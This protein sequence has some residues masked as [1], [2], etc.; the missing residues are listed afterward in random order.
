MSATA[1]MSPRT[2]ARLIGALLLATMVGGG[3]AQ[4]LVA[5]SIIVSGD[6]ATTAH[7]ILAHEAL[8]RLGFAVYLVELACQIAMTVLSYQLLK[9]ASKTAAALALAFG[10]IGCTIKTLARLFFFAPLLV[11]GGAPYLSVFDP[12]QLQALAFFS[13]R[14]NYTVETIAMVFFGLN[15]LLTGYLVLRSTFLP[16][17]LGVV[18]VVGGLGWLLYLYE[19]LAHRLESWI[20]GVGV[21]GALATVLWFLVKGVDEHRWW[22]QAGRT[23]PIAGA[24]VRS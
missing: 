15:T 23:A 2:R 10:L 13:L 9:P 8:Y 12:K 7:N 3:F 11:L 22:E 20:V 14:T 17:A 21:I 19:P 4:G 1:E 24:A 6:A 5:G 18:S 16:R